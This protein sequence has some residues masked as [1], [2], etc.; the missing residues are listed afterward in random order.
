MSEKKARAKTGT[1]ENP[2]RGGEATERESAGI[3]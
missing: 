1:D 2:A 3:K